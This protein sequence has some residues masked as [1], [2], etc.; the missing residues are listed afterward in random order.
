MPSK[1]VELTMRFSDADTPPF[2]STPGILFVRIM[3]LRVRCRFSLLRRRSEESFHTRFSGGRVPGKGLQNKV[4]DL[5]TM[6][7]RRNGAN[8]FKLFYL[9]LLGHEVVSL[10]DQSGSQ[11]EILDS[12]SL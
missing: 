12:S 5:C 1:I 6:I 2:L 4:S 11:T 3:A 9:Y 10:F 8:L 7:I